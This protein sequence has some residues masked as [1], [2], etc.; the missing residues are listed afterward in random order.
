MSNPPFLWPY[1]RS[2]KGKLHLGFEITSDWQCDVD[3][4]TDL[5]Y[6]GQLA[7]LAATYARE[8]LNYAV[9]KEEDRPPTNDLRQKNAKRTKSKN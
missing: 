2:H 9:A 1:I 7:W 5:N 4:A 6:S 8:F 3:K